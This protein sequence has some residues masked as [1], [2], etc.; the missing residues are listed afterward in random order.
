MNDI[1]SFSFSSFLFCLYKNVE[2]EN[3]F[4]EEKI[5]KEEEEGIRFGT[6]E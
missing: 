6:L 3:Y 5:E 1:F 4:R 2:Q